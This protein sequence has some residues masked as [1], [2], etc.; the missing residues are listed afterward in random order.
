MLTTT[1]KKILSS[2][3]KECQRSK[4]IKLKD[5]CPC[6]HTHMLLHCWLWAME[7]WCGAVIRKLSVLFFFAWERTAVEQRQLIGRVCSQLFN[8]RQT[9]ITDARGQH[10][11]TSTPAFDV[12][13]H[14]AHIYTAKA[15]QYVLFDAAEC[16]FM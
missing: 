12:I 13:V 2:L 8:L 5:K 4:G 10:L 11:I 7:A 6:T 9:L 1:S 3:F 15:H 14:P 16:Q